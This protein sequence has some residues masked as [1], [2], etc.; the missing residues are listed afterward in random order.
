VL[1]TGITGTVDGLSIAG[2]SHS[3]GEDQLIFPTSAAVVD[4]NGLGFRLS[5]NVTVAIF[6]DNFPLPAGEY[7]DVTS[8]A[9]GFGDFTLTAAVPEPS[10]WA[11]MILGFC[12]LG[13]MAYRRKQ[14]GPVL[15]IA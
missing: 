14:G 15:R 6:E 10:T 13:F 7:E 4:G 12:G 8:E 2:L 11:M 9:N 5:D 1:I 3:L